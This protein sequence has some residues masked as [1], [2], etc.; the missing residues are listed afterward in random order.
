MSLSLSCFLV[1]NVSSERSVHLYLTFF[2]KI[3][4]FLAEYGIPYNI[5]DI[6][7]R[8]S[9]VTESNPVVI[10]NNINKKKNKR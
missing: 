5:N 3:K 10:Y 4:S 2:S 7:K 8:V 6:N 9:N 1:Q